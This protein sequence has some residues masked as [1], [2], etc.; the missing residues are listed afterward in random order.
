MPLQFEPGFYTKIRIDDEGKLQDALQLESQDLP[1]HQHSVSDIDQPQL[2]SLIGDILSTFFANNAD[3]AVKFTYNRSTQTVTA[4]VDID[5][6]SIVKNE[7]GQ[8]KSE[9]SGSGGGAGNCANHTHTSDQIEDFEEAVKKLFDKYKSNISID[10][11][12]YVDNVT[13]KVNQY[14]QLVAVRS[15][16]E[17][18]THY[19]RDIIDYTAPP[20]A[21]TQA[22]K[23]LGEDV[24]YN[25][26]VIDFSKL[27]IGYSILALSQYIKDVV[28]KKIKDLSDR[29]NSISWDADNPRNAILSIKESLQTTAYDTQDNIYRKIY[30]RDLKLMLDFV[31]YQ[32]GKIILFEDNKE[33]A[34]ADIEKLQQV[35]DTEN[36]FTVSRLYQKNSFVARV[37]VIDVSQF[38]TKE[39]YY[40][41]HVQFKET[42]KINDSSNKIYFWATPNQK[43]DFTFIDTTPKH[44]IL[45]KEFYDYPAQYKYKI[46]LADNSKFF[47]FVPF[48]GVKEGI[49]PHKNYKLELP[50]LFSSSQVQIQF[51]LEEE[52]S[53]C[54]L[55][56]HGVNCFSGA[57]INN[58][59][60]PKTNQTCRAIFEI[61]GSELHNSLR[62]RNLQDLK[63]LAYLQKGSAILEKGF[64]AD[65]SRGGFISP[66]ILSFGNQYT[67]NKDPIQLCIDTSNEI[68]LAQVEV[69]SF[70]IQI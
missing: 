69:S 21:A 50:N 8:L 54:W 39:K 33:V 15:A 49:S 67:S 64:E 9:S 7:Y 18:H 27:N 20:P 31:P 44:T 55:F 56:K 5:E 6:V 58:V 4:D 14:G 17:K 60:T 30:Y 24:E 34:S 25:L 70:E 13:I 19:L 61:P 29:V 38:I 53:N 63:Q 47:R 1:K 57:I 41:F 51:D 10:I 68:N 23:D 37:L 12:K 48:K 3:C 40:S 35:N 32:S 36:V 43:V 22:M 52:I 2:K 28:D 59:L 42:G 66:N 65:E 16:L 45:E 26:G 11:S 46:Q 62:I